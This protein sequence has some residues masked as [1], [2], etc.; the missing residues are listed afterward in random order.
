MP[1]PSYISGMVA[2]PDPVAA[3]L[4]RPDAV[5][6]AR[7]QDLVALAL[8]GIARREWLGSLPDDPN[9]TDLAGYAA[10]WTPSRLD[11]L[12]EQ[13]GLL[14]DVD[15]REWAIAHREV[16]GASIFRNALGGTLAA[17]VILTGLGGVAV[18]GL[19]LAGVDVVGAVT[20]M[21]LPPDPPRYVGGNP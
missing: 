12:R 6:R 8:Y 20:R 9:E 1:A 13:A 5:G 2:D 3:S 19:K 15:A 4:V 14:L 18:L 17:A 21:C 10:T 16:R 7:R 11:G